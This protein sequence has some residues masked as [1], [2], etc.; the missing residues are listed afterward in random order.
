ML[1]RRDGMNAVIYNPLEDYQ[2]KCKDLHGG[3][4]EKF[5]ADLVQRSGVDVEK[6]RETVKKYN[7]FKENLQKLQKKLTWRKVFRVLM[8]ITIVLIPLVILKTNPAIKALK[9][10]IENADK[11]TEELLAQAYEQMR[12]L[13]Q[14]FTE[15]DALRLVESALPLVQFDDH[16]SVQQEVDMKINY[17]FC[18]YNSD[19]QSTVDVLAGHYNENPFLFENKLIHTMGTETYH[20]Y[21]TIRWTERYRDSSGKMQTRVKTQT[22]HATVV[23]P[24]PYYSTQVVLNYCAQGGPDL[25]FSRDATHLE[26]KSE[27]Q[28]ERLVKRGEKDLKRK[29]DKA[30]R[31][32]DDFVSMSNTDF[33]VLFDALDRTDEVQFR[34]LFT[35]LAQT[36]MVDLLLSKTGYGDDFNFIKVKRTNR[37]ISNHSQ[38]RAINLLPSHYTSYSFDVIQENFISKNKDFFKAVYFDFAPLLAIPVYQERPVHSLKPIPSQ[39]QLYALK[40]CEALANALEQRHV[41]HPDTKTQAIL[42]SAF[43]SANEHT[44]EACITAYS[45]DIEKRVEYVPMR[46]G[47]GHIHNVPVDWD[48]YLPL[49]EENHFYITAAEHTKGKNVLARRNGLCIYS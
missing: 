24:K 3:N 23:K 32:N 4:T 37:I 25:S 42:K 29:S 12:P 7:E 31:E 6:N 22:L 10:E 13:N 49:E 35:P 36:N 18:E 17:D 5:F 20:G 1:K 48:E 16:L 19:E 30:L 14:L 38:G 46:G 15:Q 2:S 39:S 47:D 33:E 28:I 45:Y 11:K 41:V 34:T 40:E 26:Q 43:V 44:D 21:K 8:C 27:R 9:Q